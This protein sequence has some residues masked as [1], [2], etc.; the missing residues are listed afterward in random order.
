MPDIEKT[1][2][3]RENSNLFADAKISPDTYFDNFL[4]HFQGIISYG[5]WDNEVRGR[6]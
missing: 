6:R 4:V 3:F 5:E 2:C 1:P